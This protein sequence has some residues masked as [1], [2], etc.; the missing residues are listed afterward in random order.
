[1]NKFNVKRLLTALIVGIVILNIASPFQGMSDFWFDAYVGV[2][3]DVI[4]EKSIGIWVV[5]MFLSV[6]F[7][8]VVIPMCFYVLLSEIAIQRSN[9]LIGVIFGVTCFFVGALSLLM[10]LPLFVHLP[11]NFLAVRGFWSLINLVLAG[12][13]VGG[14]YKPIAKRPATH[15]ENMSPI[16]S[17]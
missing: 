16:I 3:S 11:I 8:Q 15:Q 7:F 14:I 6:V 4:V 2:P 17:D 5:K 12:G 10:L 13:I 9:I 1:M